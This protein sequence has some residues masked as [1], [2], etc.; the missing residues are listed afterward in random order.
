MGY[1]FRYS[2]LPFSLVVVVLIM[3]HLLIDV[4][5]DATVVRSVLNTWE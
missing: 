2:T 4:A 5:W 1:L 3:L